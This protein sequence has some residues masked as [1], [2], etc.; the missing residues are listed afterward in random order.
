MALRKRIAL[1]SAQ[2]YEAYQSQFVE[3][4]LEE[5]FGYDYDVCIFSTFRKEPESAAKE[6]GEASIFSLVNYDEFDAVVVMADM[7]R[8]SDILINIDNSLKKKFKGKVLY[9]EKEHKDY[10]SILMN[11]YQ[12]M[13][14][15]VSHMIEVHGYRD[16]AYVSG[17]KWHTYS[18]QRINAFYDCMKE[19]NLEVPDNY[20]YYGNFWYEGGHE[21]ASCFIRNHMDKVA[22]LP[23]AIIC[24]NDY[25]AIGVSEELEILGY[26]IPEDVAVVGY[27]SVVKGQMC[28]NPLTSVYVPARQFG[29]FAANSI[30][31]LLNGEDIEPFY[32]KTEMFIG[33]S[34]GCTMDKKQGHGLATY[35][36]KDIEDDETQYLESFIHLMEDLVLQS[37]FKGLLD[38]VQ[39]YTY[40]IR[41]FDKF[42][43]FLNDIWMDTESIVNYE[44]GNR[45]YTAQVV[46]VLNCGRSGEGADRL[47]FESRFET[48]R[49]YEGL[50]EESKYPRAFIFSPVFY[51]DINFGYAMLSYGN[52]TNVYGDNYYRWM[53]SIM[54]ALECYRRKTVAFY[55]EDAGKESQII[56]HMTGMFNYSGFTKHAVPMIERGKSSKLYTAILAIDISGLDKINSKLGRSE[57]DR[58]ISELARII[59]E[60]ADE[61]AMCCRLGND[62]FIV[63][64]L[65]DDFRSEII[66]EVQRR[67]DNKIEE[68]NRLETTKLPLQ[69]YGGI[70][71]SKVDNLAQMEDLVNQAVSNKNGNKANEQRM[72]YSDTLNE[73][74][75]EQAGLVKKILD[76][77]LFTYHFQPIVNAKDGSI[78]AYE[79]LM[80]STTERFVS[81]LDIIKYATILKRLVDI[82]KATFNNVMFIIENKSGMF[83]GKKV[84]INSIPGINLPP[85][86]A[87]SIG[88]RIESFPEKIVIELTEQS[89]ADDAMLD[90]MKES[91]ARMG[92]ETAVDDYG[93]GYSNIVNLL[94]YM[95]DYVK[96]DRMLLSNIQDNPQKQHFV[97]DIVIF[98]KENN[99]KVLAEGVETAQELEKVIELGADLIQGY[100]TARPNAEILQE[101]DPDIQKEIQ[102]YSKKYE[103]V[104]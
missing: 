26:R 65:V 32:N 19:H 71:V 78:F 86:E 42:H 103:K 57:G 70:A 50:Y 91:Y 89:E 60:S 58:T 66:Y 16:I 97:K 55:R 2:L 73:E 35:T 49:M 18:K 101:I 11:H 46:P 3:G 94:R 43:I 22:K 93:T 29:E 75:K 5:A 13:K 44:P 48:K 17:P 90:N 41:E 99:F 27:D 45:G 77:N 7:L 28:P 72:K 21:A 15:L 47:D 82:D 31:R 84:F 85:E 67:I 68:Y 62:E 1:L 37:D 63:A 79:A 76:E 98:A 34:C 69:I 59:N 100:Y 8:A 40:Q 53:R 92:V 102:E 52:E 88:K 80:R 61:G 6:I 38:M 81:P 24:A 10:P 25:M 9:V 30:N 83:D 33:S 39:T 12:P 96:I 23:Q 54:T 51:D 87:E 4:F 20:V 14:D 56:D 36:W 104:Y 64:E 74:E 95:P